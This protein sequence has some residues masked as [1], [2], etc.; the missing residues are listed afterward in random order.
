MIFIEMTVSGFFSIFKPKK[1]ENINMIVLTKILSERQKKIAYRNIL[2]GEPLGLLISSETKRLVE[3]NIFPVE[4]TVANPKKVYM[5]DA[6]P[7]AD[8]PRFRVMKILRSN[9]RACRA[10][11]IAVRIIVS[12]A[13]LFL[14]ILFLHSIC[15][16]LFYHYIFY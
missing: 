12:F 3:T 16:L 10:I 4:I 5:R 13:M 9:D 7:T 6:I 2:F 11:W 14:F 1:S 8:V 15:S